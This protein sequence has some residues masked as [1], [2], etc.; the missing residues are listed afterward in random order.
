MDCV[1]VSRAVNHG[2]KTQLCQTKDY[3]IG[4]YCFSVKHGAFRSK[5][6]WLGIIII[7]LSGSTCLTMDCCFSELAL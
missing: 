7:C 5:T 6:G 4:I 1:L 2:F 3:K